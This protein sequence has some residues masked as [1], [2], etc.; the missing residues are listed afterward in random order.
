MSW[1]AE[2][3][4]AVHGHGMTLLSTSPRCRLLPVLSYCHVAVEGQALASGA[5]AKAHHLLT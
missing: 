4:A 3:Q 1:G 2:G 5:G